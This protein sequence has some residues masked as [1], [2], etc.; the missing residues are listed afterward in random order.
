MLPIITTDHNYIQIFKAYR[1]VVEAFFSL[2][3]EIRP[4]LFLTFRFINFLRGFHMNIVLNVT[5]CTA[6][7][8]L[9]QQTV[10]TVVTAYPMCML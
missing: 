9:V 2:S 4:G 6:S 5:G 1:R 3:F 7:L 8:A 10:T